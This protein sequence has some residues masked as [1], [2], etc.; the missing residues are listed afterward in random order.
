MLP[1]VYLGIIFLVI[2][3]LLGFRKPMYQ[4]ILGGLLVTV[5][6]FKI[7][8]IKWLEFPFKVLTH[9]GTLS[10]LISFYLITYLQRVL[11]LR[12]QI[13]LAE[14]DLDGIFHNR[15]VNT[16]GAPMFIGLLPSAAA[17]ILCA[18]IVKNATDDYL[19]PKE[20]AFVA[21]WFRHI[22]ESSLPTYPSVLLMVTLT[23]VA[24]P[25]I[26]MGMFIPAL[27]LVGIGYFLYLRRLPKHPDTPKS[28]DRKRDSVNLVKHLWSLGLI[29]VLI[30]VFKFQVVTA[31][32]ITILV[33]LFVYRFSLGEAI[34]LIPKSWENKLLGN[35][36]LVL[37]FK[38]FIDYTGVLILLPDALS[39]LPIPSFLVFAILFFWGGIISGASGIT[40]LGAPMLM[41]AIPD[42]GIAIVILMLCMVH[43]ASQLS[44]THICLIVSAEYFDVSLLDLLRKTLPAVLIFIVL[45]IGY[46]MILSTIL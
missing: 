12:E 11:E 24:L 34:K 6:L 13:R 27:T 38:E 31:A 19:N 10:I 14:R 9:W 44:P 4:A 42:G 5:I 45:M 41:A 2:I 21:S 39:L 17:M 40:A 20:Q 32:L 43:A 23:G 7:P 8:P 37:T 16:A 29:L 25:H 35:M 30:L 3:T 18:D 1:I 22:P 33:C 15:R 26:M 28:T 36:F 46:Y